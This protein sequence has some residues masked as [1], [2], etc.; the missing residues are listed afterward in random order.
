MWYQIIFLYAV[1]YSLILFVFH[2]YFLR[3][4]K[5]DAS[6][7]IE[8]AN[9]L[10]VAESNKLTIFIFVYFGAFVF[11]IIKTILSGDYI[12]LLSALIAIIGIILF[13][14]WKRAVNRRIKKR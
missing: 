8:E 11:Y 13:A 1:L 9:K 4:A 5:R 14:L 10:N 7:S 2:R 3:I 6:L 12:D